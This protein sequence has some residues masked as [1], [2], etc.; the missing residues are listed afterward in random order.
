LFEACFST[1]YEEETYWQ[2]ILKQHILLFFC[3]HVMRFFQP[4]LILVLILLFLSSCIQYR[5]A[6]YFSPFNGNVPIYHTTPL[7]IDSVKTGTY[8]GILLG[9]GG[10]NDNLHDDAY[11][12][13]PSLYRSYARENCQFYFGGN[14]TLG[15]YYV[16][17]YDTIPATVRYGVTR[18]YLNARIINEQGGNKFFGGLGL[19]AGINYTI[20]FRRRH[21]WR[22]GTETSYNHEFGNYIHFRNELADSAATVIHRQS[23]FITLGLFT[24]LAFKLKKG[25]IG[26]KVAIG[27]PL[28]KNYRKLYRPRYD[29]ERFSF[30]YVSPAFQYTNNR[31]TGFFQINLSTKAFHGQLGTSYRLN[32]RGSK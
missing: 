31:L 14:V 26:F 7:Q 2:Y 19:Q 24:E 23:H 3:Q 13:R 6:Y 32:T 20:Q 10:A 28:G 21:E 25:S 18:D 16:N 22:I 4:L 9:G 1:D 29:A 11:Y 15:N 30:A 27:T 17:K 12:F 8:G 5:E